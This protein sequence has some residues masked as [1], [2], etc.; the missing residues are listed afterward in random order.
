MQL[1]SRL[2]EMARRKMSLSP[3]PIGVSTEY[4]LVNTPDG[5][6]HD[7]WQE[8][9]VAKAQ[10]EAFLPLLQDAREGKPRLDFLVAA[11][12]IQ[13]S[14]VQDPV[15][16][17]VGCGSGYYSEVL[18]LLMSEPFQYIGIDY[19]NAMTSLAHRFYPSIPFA[20]GDACRLPLKTNSCDVLLSGTSLMHILDYK[21]A[22]AE[23]VRVSR[24]WCIFH[25]VPV[26]AVQSTKIVRKLAYGGSVVEIIFNRSEIESVLV[27][28]GCQIQESFE[29]I[30]YDVSTVV[31][32]RT[33]TLTYLC[34][35]KS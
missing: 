4:S 35:K 3:K 2:I 22:V 15:V 24:N 21:T 1:I 19:S 14:D 18:A 12:A 27:S 30:P 6:I 25:T 16:V 9:F 32:E 33:W 26:M 29:S 5:E 20:T 7:G 8:D 28:N 11:L 13:A 31:G 17:E 34:R 10:H 23:S